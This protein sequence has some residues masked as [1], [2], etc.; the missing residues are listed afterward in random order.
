MLPSLYEGL[1]STQR[2]HTYIFIAFTGEE[3]GELGSA[4]YVR[5]MTKEQ[6]AQSKAMVNLDTLCL[7]PTKVWLSRS[8]KRLTSLLNG[9]ANAMKLP[10]GAVNVEKVGR[11]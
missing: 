8:D 7:G 10:L 4:T 1:R 3:R 6:L 5:E 11:C 9:L 2:Q